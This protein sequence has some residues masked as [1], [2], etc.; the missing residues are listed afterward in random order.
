MFFLLVARH[1]R[2]RLVVARGIVEKAQIAKKTWRILTKA[3]PQ[4]RRPQQVQVQLISVVICV[5]F[6]DKY[7]IEKR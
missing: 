4:R 7:L 3:V 1:I 2:V 5:I 6:I